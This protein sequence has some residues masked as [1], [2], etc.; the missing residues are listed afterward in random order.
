[1]AF[2]TPL[3]PKYDE[4]VSPECR[5]PVR[6]LFD[7]MKSHKVKIGLWIDLCNTDRWYNKRDV[8]QLECKY[9]KIQCRGHGE[10]P[11]PDAVNTFVNICRKFAQQNPLQIIAVHCTHGFNRTGFLIASYLIETEDWAPE[12][13]LISF[14][15]AR[16]PG[17]YKADYI[18]DLM[19]RYGGDPS[20]APAV[21]DMP[22]WCFED[23]QQSDDT[24]RQVDDDGH[25]VNDDE[26]AVAGG[27][28][29]A[30]GADQQPGKFRR[31]KKTSGT[32]MEGVSGVTS[33]TEQPLLKEIQKK[34]QKMCGWRSQ[35]FPGSQ[36]VSMTRE[37]IKLIHDMPYKVS[38]KADG[39][40]YMMLIDGR[41][42]VFFAD[43]DHC[44][45]KV[46]K[47]TF[48]DRKSPEMS[49]YLKDTLVDGE[50]VV[51]EFKGVR[52]PRYLIYDA[53]MFKGVEVGKTDFERRELCIHKELIDV[54]N[55]LIVAG[56]ID[57]AAESFSVR[58]KQFWE[59][60]E[61]PILLG[62]KFTKESLGHEP[63]GLIFQP[64]KKPYIAGR[65]DDI[66]KW[67]P[68][69]HNSIDF[70]L[71]IFKDD[72]P[73]MLGKPEGHLY[74][75]G[76]N[77]PAAMIKLTK[78]LKQ[79]N[80]KIVE[81]KYD[82]MTGQW[83]FM[84]ERTDKSFPNSMKTAEAVFNSI[85]EPVTDQMLLQFIDRRRFGLDSEFRPPPPKVARH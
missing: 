46:D 47:L 68:S 22:A 84:R 21:P 36:P 2:K 81:C 40:R 13:A 32:F 20:D 12:A 59:V 57:K 18:E 4:Q 28:A 67:K 52:T 39:T 74:V 11:S 5:F 41:D 10:A 6:M 69:S 65:D 19:N 44:I 80:N 8:E 37:N 82:A 24:G 76:N 35:G 27:A 25:V 70:K 77:T 61:T 66:L 75:G 48:K 14:A 43:R 83:I 85:K 45:F 64:K 73:G 58:Q 3:D 78:E 31:G 71:K 79:L 15:Q 60:S 7:V 16:P 49:E 38:W 23:E 62:P 17:I 51:D 34:I 33:V 9:V 55:K 54:R 42:R 63:D 56:G 1:L 53:I 50:M 29:A 30:E 72:R 26:D